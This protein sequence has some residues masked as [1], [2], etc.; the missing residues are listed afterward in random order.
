MKNIKHTKLIKKN[1]KVIF[2]SKDK[3]SC[4]KALKFLIHN[5][6]IQIAAVVL[7]KN[8]ELI[9]SNKNIYQ[10]C[11]NF[12]IK[13]VQEED[14]YE[15]IEKR[16]KKSDFVKDIDIVISFLYW[17]KIK[18]PII[19]LPKI[20]CLN[21]HPAPLPDYRG[22]AGYSF[23]ILNNIKKWGVSAHFIDECF[24][25]G[26]IIKVFRFPIDITKET[27]YTLEMKSQKFLFLLFENIINTIINGKKLFRIPQK[28]KK[29]TY[30]SY[31]KFN[32]LRRIKNE[33]SIEETNKKIRAFWFPP[34]DGAI[35]NIQGTDFTIINSFVLNQIFDFMKFKK[36]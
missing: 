28:K 6:H 31:K 32:E 27:A 35:I 15:E 36:L 13:Q 34:H 1:I 10:L 22:V 24:D 8:N 21:F 33:D 2:M 11:K 25:T 17:K 19:D 18:K 12:N 26:D 29:G 20:G 16:N 9:V 4:Y 23:G 5:S 14:V 3:D 30:Y 7:P